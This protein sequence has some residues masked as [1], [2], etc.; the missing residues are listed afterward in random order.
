MDIE[1]RKGEEQEYEES[2]GAS[3]LA[4]AAKWWAAISS[5]TAA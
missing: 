5:A 4:S 3:H 2:V 1:E